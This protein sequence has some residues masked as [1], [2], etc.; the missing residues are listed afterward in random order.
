MLGTATCKE[1]GICSVLPKDKNGALDSNDKEFMV[2]TDN[3][4][5]P[6]T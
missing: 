4:H 1:L 3:P 5:L 2:P 6:A